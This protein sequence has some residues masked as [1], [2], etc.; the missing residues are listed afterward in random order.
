MLAQGLNYDDLLSG[1]SLPGGYYTWEVVAYLPDG[2]QVSNTGRASMSVLKPS[3]RR[4]PF[5]H[6]APLWL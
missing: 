6:T 3:L 5:R 1:A 2:R 4:S